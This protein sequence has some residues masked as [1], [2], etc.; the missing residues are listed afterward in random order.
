MYCRF[1]TMRKKMDA[2]LASQAGSSGTTAPATPTATP[3]RKRGAAKNDGVDHDSTPAKKTKASGGRKGG[4]AAA[5]V[6]SEE[7]VEGDDD[8]EEEVRADSV[9]GDHD[10]FGGGGMG[11]QNGHSIF[12][13]S[14]DDLAEDF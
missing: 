8:D 7:A 12:G 1:W 13:G 6:K 5:K 3:K 11:F 10:T 14:A 2:D 9:A 4:K